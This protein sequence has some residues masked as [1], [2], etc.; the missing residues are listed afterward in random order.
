MT[1]DSATFDGLTLAVSVDDESLVALGNRIEE[2]DI[3]LGAFTDEEIAAVTVVDDDTLVPLPQLDAVPVEQ[4]APLFDA[5]MR[6]LIARRLLAL[7]STVGEIVAVGALGTVL[8]FREQPDRVLVVERVTAEDPE[9]RVVY[10]VGSTPTVL[11]EE[12][13]AVL[14]HHIFTLRSLVT[15]AAALTT[16]LPDSVEVAKPPA[17]EVERGERVRAALED[18]QGVTRV[19]ALRRREEGGYDEVRASILESDNH[20]RW[21]VFLEPSGDDMTQAASFSEAELS[22]EDFFTA[23]LSV[24]LDQLPVPRTD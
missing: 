4:R 10:S 12:A 19:Y 23:C 2:G 13:V 9:R 24:D 14:G 15:E 11:L 1:L 22:L 8:S 5:A 7:T 16:M 6:S 18:L 17:D 20:G 3:S 21:V